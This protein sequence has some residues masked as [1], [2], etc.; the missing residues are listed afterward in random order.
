MVWLTG[1][2]TALLVLAADFS[3]PQ[4]VDNV[5]LH[6]AVGLICLL[7]APVFAGAQAVVTERRWQGREILAPRAAFLYRSLL[8]SNLV[9]WVF[10]CI[11]FL[12]V[13][14]WPQIIR[15]NWG[16]SRIPL[17]DEVAIAVPMIGSIVLSWVL[18]YGAERSLSSA[19]SL[20]HSPEERMGLAWQRFRTFSGLVLLPVLI[21]FLGRDLLHIAFPDGV[22]ALG[23]TIAFAMFLLALAGGYPWLLSTVWRTG[24][25]KDVDLIERLRESDRRAG[26]RR[27]DVR[28]WNTGG[29]VINAVAVGL[30]PGIRRIFLSDKLL[31]EFESD[32]VVAIYRHELGHLVYNHL[33]MRLA[34]VLV[35]LLALIMLGGSDVSGMASHRD[36]YRVNGIQVCFWIILMFLLLIYLS[37]VVARFIRKSEVQADLFAVSTPGG[38]LCPRLATIYCQALL[39]MA[40]HAPEMLDRS[41]AAHPAVRIRIEVIRQAMERPERVG[42]FHRQFRLEQQVAAICLASLV[43]GVILVRHWV[44]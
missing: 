44:V 36:V 12:A 17:L 14:R 25:P 4:P 39:K 21:L 34:L 26:L 42:R 2:I 5:L 27:Q 40:S 20:A 35:P 3:V 28:I 37:R 8:G 38:Q 24:K 41:T 7:M 11:A 30:V 13:A 43:G 33:Q 22:G 29:T 9:V 23:T 31:N 32:E 15:E 10:G 19:S 6:T 18:I 16:W 1:L